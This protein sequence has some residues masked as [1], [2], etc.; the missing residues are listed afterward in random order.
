[1]TQDRTFKVGDSVARYRID[2][3]LGSGGM[4]YVYLARDLAL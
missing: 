1:M 4:G 2:G 3:V